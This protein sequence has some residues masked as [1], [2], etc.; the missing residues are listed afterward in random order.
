MRNQYYIFHT[1]NHITTI[2]RMTDFYNY[3]IVEHI[4]D[5]LRDVFFLE[6]ARTEAGNLYVIGML[7]GEK[8]D[9]LRTLFRVTTLDELISGC[10]PPH[11]LNLESHRYIQDRFLAETER[12]LKKLC[13]ADVPVHHMNGLLDKLT[14]FLHYVGNTNHPQEVA[15][16]IRTELL[17]RYDTKSDTFS[18]DLVN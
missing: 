1:A 12:Q 5:L 4:K 10:T 15:L 6:Q 8:K 2:L 17:Q 9:T 18:K 11:A 7:L 13:L 16:R 14:L 3:G